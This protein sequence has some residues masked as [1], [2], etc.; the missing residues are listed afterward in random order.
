MNELVELIVVC[1]PALAALFAVLYAVSRDERDNMR[2]AC[3]AAAMRE[4]GR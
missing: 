3:R 4:L 2:G 1:V